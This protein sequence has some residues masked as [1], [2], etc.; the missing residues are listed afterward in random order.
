MTDYKKI[1]KE[2]AKVYFLTLLIIPLSFF[3]RM[4]YARNLT[5]VDYGLF[6]GLFAF[7]GFFNFLRDWGLNSAT[8]HFANKYIVHNEKSKIKT[9]FFIDMGFNLFMSV[10]IGLVLYFLKGVIASGIYKNEGNIG[11][12][13]DFFIVFWIITAI[14][15][16]NGAF[17]SVFQEQRIPKFFEF[18]NWLLILVLSFIGFAFIESYKVPVL[19]YLIAMIIVCLV[20]SLLFFIKHNDI[21]RVEFYKGKDLGKEVFKYAS[22]VMIGGLSSILLSQTDLFLIQLFIGARNVAYYSSGF[23][24]A[25]LLIILVI[26]LLIIT[27]P[28]FVR[29]WHSGKK[30]ELS[31]LISFIF[32]NM[33]VFVLPFS[34]FFFAFSSQIVSLVYGSAFLE[35][36]VI[37]K[38]FS[39][40]FIIKIFNMFLFQILWSTGKPKQTSIIIVIAGIANIILDLILISIF[41]NIG[42]AVAT[43]ICYLLI[44]IL[45]LKEILKEIPI[46]VNILNNAKIVLSSLIFLMACF[47]L[48]GRINLFDIGIAKYNFVLNGGTVFVISLAVYMACLILF[49]IIT[50]QKI[51]I[52]IGLFNQKDVRNDNSA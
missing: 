20:Y 44:M 33:L 7:F 16:L 36:G 14:Y 29:L 32:N 46:K 6:Y 42:A 8:I 23:A 38:I 48:R 35:S 49:G 25:S 50:K 5:L 52:V 28:L 4:I 39:F 9:L 51:K 21:F 41:Q 27:H 17:F 19:A 2:T 12:M 10:A 18:L 24:A 30:A 13:F 43:S 31:R 11:Y 47:I 26:P 15:K 1:A 34:M 40:A 37:L 22:A 45:C 3:V